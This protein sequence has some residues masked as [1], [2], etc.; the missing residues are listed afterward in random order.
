MM[1]NKDIIYNKILESIKKNKITLK[2]A[3]LLI[4]VIMEE[5]E[6]IKNLTGDDKK[7]YVIEI[8]NTIVSNGNDDLIPPFICNSV[9]TLID[10]GT[11][12]LIIDSIVYTTNNKINI[13]IATRCSC[14]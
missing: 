14:I 4:T 11:I 7:L 12:G 8:L 2:S 13:N 10:N 5:V 3:F 9:K 6:K 1:N